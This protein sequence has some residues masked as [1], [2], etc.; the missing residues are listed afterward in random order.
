[1]KKY[2]DFSKNLIVTL[3]PITN[4]VSAIKRI[5]K[6]T[7]IFRLNGSHNTITWHK[8][9]SSSIKRQNSKNVILLDIPGIK[10]RT[11]N[12][13]YINIKKKEK[14][15][16]YF[17]KTKTILNIDRF[18]KISNEIPFTKIKKKFFSIDDG[19]NQF[20]IFDYNKDYI[21]GISQGS[22][23]LKSNKGLNIPESIYNE[24]KQFNKYSTFLRKAKK[25]N[26]DAI[27]LSFIQSKDLLVKIKKIYSNKL[28]ISKIEN[29]Q[30]IR[31]SDEIVQYS[32]AVMI[33]RGD[34]AAEIGSNKLF[35]AVIEISRLCKKYGTPLIMATEN[36]ESMIKNNSP[37]KSEIM[38]LELN[39]LISVDKIML[40]SETAISSNWKNIISWLDEYFSNYK[41]SN[42]GLKLIKKT[43][44]IY[45][46][47]T[48][49]WSSLHLNESQ[50]LL[51]STK[52][53]SAIYK[54]KQ[55]LDKPRIYIFTDNLKTYF[56]SKFFCNTKTFLVPKLDKKNAAKQVLFFA[57]KYSKYLFKYTSNIISIFVLNPRKG[58]R[59]NSVY[60]I[61]K[62]D[63]KI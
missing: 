63:L 9:T 25:V 62:K 37:S 58:A 2:K 35:N 4:S 5:A 26:F 34:L 46:K 59:A 16:F 13:E 11:L 56:L 17:R 22:F 6:S 49:I 45:N 54:C 40:S 19:L 32:D 18:V 48:S 53:G 12:T 38:S 21:I 47:E 55:Y 50:T 36:L 8:K 14:I 15:C 57:K 1:M 42:H 39:K 20:K 33:D 10:P 27:G 23:E 44:D 31:N 41:E 30:G 7:D 60:M 52:S 3:G 61:N 29:Y 24:T 28:I 51:I 43:K